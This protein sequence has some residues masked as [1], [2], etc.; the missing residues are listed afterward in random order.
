MPPFLRR[1]LLGSAVVSALAVLAVPLASANALDPWS[2][3]AQAPAADLADQGSADL[4]AA[5]QAV[6]NLAT[7]AVVESVAAG[8]DSCPDGWYC[9]FENSDFTGR[10]L[11]FGDPEFWQDLD[12]WRF[13]LQASAWRNRLQDRG[14]QNTTQLAGGTL[15]FLWCAA[16]GQSGSLAGSAADDVTTHLYIDP[17]GTVCYPGQGPR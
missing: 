7:P 3:E 4:A 2:Q 9:L 6:A 5:D 8:P 16:P 1:L 13:R 14:V 11:K 12:Q 15:E 10:M 17:T